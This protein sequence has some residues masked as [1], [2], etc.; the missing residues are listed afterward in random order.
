MSWQKVASRL[1]VNTSGAIKSLISRK[2]RQSFSSAE[3]LC[4]DNVGSYSCGV[5]TELCANAR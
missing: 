2:L 1:T 5:K 4:A 3:Q